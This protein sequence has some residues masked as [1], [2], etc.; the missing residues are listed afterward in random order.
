MRLCI[1]I[2]DGEDIRG[3]FLQTCVPGSYGS[4][5]CGEDDLQGKCGGQVRQCLLGLQVI[6]LE[7]D[8]DFVSRLK[9]LRERVEAGDERCRP[10]VGGDQHSDGFRWVLHSWLSGCS[11]IREAK[12]L[13]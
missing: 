2:Q 13:G 10:S 9:L 3:A 11:V 6:V 12:R 1:V 8:D 4:W 7:H 5:N